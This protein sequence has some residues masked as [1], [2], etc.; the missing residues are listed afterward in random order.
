MPKIGN[1]RILIFT[2]TALLLLSCSLAESF[3]G[4][5]RFV[6]ISI[7]SVANHPMD[8]LINPISGEHSFDGIPFSILSG[9]ISVFQTQHHLLPA[10]PVNAS[11]Q[12]D[13]RH[14]VRAYILI[15]VG[16]VYKSLEGKIAGSITLTFADG[17]EIY[18]SLLA[19]INLRENWAYVSGPTP[20][21]EISGVVTELAETK[22]WMNV[23]SEQQSRGTGNALGYIDMVIIKIPMPLQLSTLQSIE[24]ADLL[25]DP[26][27]ILYGITIE[28]RD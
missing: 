18:R 15:N 8:N 28:T 22:E 5:P 9:S 7:E 10:Y 14:P 12:V 3:S 2:L 6:N 11:I 26:S 13:I 27:I 23:F 24:V 25:L 17:S 19:G 20:S 4:S 16:Y 1:G 21:M